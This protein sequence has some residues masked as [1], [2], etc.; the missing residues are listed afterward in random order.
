VSALGTSHSSRD[1]RRTPNAEHRSRC[2][3]EC[4]MSNDSATWSCSISLRFGT[5]GTTTFSP[6]NLNRNE[7]DIWLR[8]A[9]VAILNP[10]QPPQ[11]YTAIS[12]S[13]IRRLLDARNEEFTT[14]TIVVRVLDPNATNLLFVDLP[15]MFSGPVCTH[16]VITAIILQGSFLTAGI[17]TCPLS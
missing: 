13:E 3:I 10:N 9:Q 8:R 2:P 5:D 14:D 6:T 4:S 12:E 17:E 15:G 11:S 7:V 16:I 1:N